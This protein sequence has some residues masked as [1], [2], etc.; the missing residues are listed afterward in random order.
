MKIIIKLKIRKYW[1][2]RM[3]TFRKI[4]SKMILQQI[5]AVNDFMSIY[6]M[7]I[8][9]LFIGNLSKPI[10]SIRYSFSQLR[11]IRQT[12]DIE[13]EDVRKRYIMHNRWLFCHVICVVSRTKYIVFDRIQDTI[14]VQNVEYDFDIAKICFQNIFYHDQSISQFNDSENSN[15][16]FQR[17]F[18][19]VSIYQFVIKTKNQ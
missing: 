18:D 11:V 15:S 5:L 7:S 19:D 10:R 12:N 6:S 3:K 2:R 8:S 4:D 9:S 1:N 17:H 16:Y 14:D 13:S